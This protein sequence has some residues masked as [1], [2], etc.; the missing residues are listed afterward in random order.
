[1]TLPTRTATRNVMWS[2]LISASYTQWTYFIAKLQHRILFLFNH[3][4]WLAVTMLCAISSSVSGEL[5]KKLVCISALLP[6][7]L[8]LQLL[9][10]FS[11]VWLIFIDKM[12]L[13]LGR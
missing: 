4:I 1:M 9:Y 11:S 7:S 6:W 13:L 8:S 2:V 12:V 3:L 5:E 10:T